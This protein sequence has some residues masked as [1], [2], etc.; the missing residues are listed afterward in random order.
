MRNYSLVTR[1]IWNLEIFSRRVSAYLQRARIK[2]Q[3]KDL[4]FID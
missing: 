1:C 4:E 3:L 2:S